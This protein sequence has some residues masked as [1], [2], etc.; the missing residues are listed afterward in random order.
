MDPA[1]QRQPVLS[2]TLGG[3]HEQAKELQ[4][5]ISQ[6]LFVGDILFSYGDFYEQGH[7]LVP[8]PYVSEWWVQ[9]IKAAGGPEIDSFK[10]M[11]FKESLEISKKYKCPQG[12]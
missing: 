3:N 1:E 8:S 6:I 5:R 9:D 4:R 7:F 11:D 2:R 10:E 12:E